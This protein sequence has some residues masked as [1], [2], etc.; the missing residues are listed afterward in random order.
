MSLLT[1][2]NYTLAYNLAVAAIQNGSL[3]IIEYLEGNSVKLFEPYVAVDLAKTALNKDHDEIVKHIVNRSPK[4]ISLKNFELL[5]S[6]VRKGNMELLERFIDI[7]PNIIHSNWKQ[8]AV[9][10]IQYNQPVVLSFLK[11]HFR[12]PSKYE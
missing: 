1:Y 12:N 2:K 6:A 9:E 4:I 11:Q 8:I 3:P 10:A 5:F 7:D